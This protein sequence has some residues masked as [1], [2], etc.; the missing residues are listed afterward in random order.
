MQLTSSRATTSCQYCVASAQ[1]THGSANVSRIAVNT[2]R[3]PKRSTSIPTPMRAGIVNATLQISSVFTCSGERC[4]DRAIE[5]VNGARLNQTTN[6]RKNDTQVNCNI[7]Q[8][9]LACIGF[10]NPFAASGSAV[11]GWQV[12]ARRKD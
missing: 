1:N 8:R 2:F 6:V 5:L 9:F 4:S 3:G 11:E 12:T 7:F 10:P